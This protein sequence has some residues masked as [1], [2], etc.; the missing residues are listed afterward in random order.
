M[1]VTPTGLTACR[2]PQR[3]RLGLL[4]ALIQFIH[5]VETVA[6][7]DTAAWAATHYLGILMCALGMVG[8]TGIYL[9]QVR[10]TGVLG[11]IGYLMLWS[12]F[13]VD[14]RVP[15]RR[16][17]RHARDGRRRP[18][19]APTNLLAIATGKDTGDLGAVVAI[20]PITGV[21]YLVGGMVFA[22]SLYRARI[23]ARWASVTLAVGGPS[24]TL[25][26]PVVP[27]SV[28]RL[29][30]F[31]VALAMVGLGI[32]LWRSHRSP[33]TTAPAPAFSLAVR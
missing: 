4:F 26:V 24:I 20:W 23:L 29:F 3:R 15:V 1:T 13:V 18:G 32:S 6:N 17:V 7:V 31:P 28:A 27:H 16:G 14:G 19:P 33:A 22:I 8:V 12:F 9:R 11:L 25:A 21:L 5:P 10:E 30:A 2:R